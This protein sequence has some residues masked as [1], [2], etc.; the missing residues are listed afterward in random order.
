MN[1]NLKSS[2][3]PNITLLVLSLVGVLFSGLSLFLGEILLPIIIASLALI[4][5]YDYT[6]KKIFSVVSSSLIV[7]VNF[8]FLILK[9]SY[10]FFSL[11]AIIIAFLIVYS[12][13]RRSSK[14]EASYI[15]MLISAAFLLI[16]AM[17]FGMAAMGEYTFDAALDY[18]TKQWEILRDIFSKVSFE[19]YADAFSQMGISVSTDEFAK[20]F[21]QQKNYIISYLLIASFAIVGFSFKLFSF[22]GSKLADDTTTFRSWRFITTNVFAYFYMILIFASIFVNSSVGV[23]AITVSNLYNVFVVIYAYVG[24]NYAL[25]LL[26]HRM[27]PGIALLL[28]AAA[29]IMLP[30]F[31]LQLLSMLGVL[32]TI[33][34]NNEPSPGAV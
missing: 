16:S 14:A 26:S 25:S 2:L 4:Y 7:L 33:R 12:F 19:L 17:F 23:F 3:S 30:S 9:I 22:V 28:I 5:L 8:V 13:Y 32:F 11:Q 27:K 10:S 29:L 18:Y 24:F 20:I 6:N 34:K 15:M 21:D 1:Q 31:A